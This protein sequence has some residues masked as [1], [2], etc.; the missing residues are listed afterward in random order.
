MLGLHLQE[1]E[2]FF[3]FC[4]FLQYVIFQHFRPKLVIITKH[5]VQEK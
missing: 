2:S 5:L 4:Y 3:F 1:A